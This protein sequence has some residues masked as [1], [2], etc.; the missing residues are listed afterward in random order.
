MDILDIVYDILKD[1]QDM[2]NNIKFFEYPDVKESDE[3]KIIIDPMDSPAPSDYGDNEWLTLDFQIQI[4]VFS[5]ERKKTNNI[6]EKIRN[7]MWN[8]L[9]FHQIPG[10][11]RYESGV[12]RDAR[13]Y[14]GK[15]YRDDKE[16]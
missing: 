5:N 11:R 9:K 10:P 12:F 13:R 6:A 14:R 15:I 3:V 1:E 7:I 4:D 16:I 8:E 2:K